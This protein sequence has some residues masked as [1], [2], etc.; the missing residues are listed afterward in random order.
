MSTRRSVGAVAAVVGCLVAVS[1]YA[2]DFQ[3]PAPAPA[4]ANLAFIDGAVDVVQDGVAAPADPPVMLIEGDLVRT[5]N[6]RAE[7][8]FGDG[9]LL[10]L[11]HDTEIEILGE[12]RL[13]LR[14]GRALV[15]V[16]HAAI[17]PYVIDTPSSSVTL[18]AEGEYDVTAT[19]A[20]RFV[21]AVARGA[22]SI[23]YGQRWSIRGGQMLS[24]L[25]PGGRP[26]IE[27]F[28]SARWDAFATW[29]Y[30]RASGFTTSASSAQLPY[31]L[32]P[33]GP[34]LDRYGR[35]DYLEPHGYVWFPS[36]GAAWRP[37]G[38]GAWSFGRY[39]WTWH[40]RDR[41]AWPTH[42]YGRWG[43]TGSF[44]Y[45]APSTVWAPAWVTWSVAPGYVGWAPAGWHGLGRV[46]RWGRPDHPAYAPHDG[47]WRGWTVVPR[48]QFEPRRKVRPSAVDADRLDEATR[49]A[50]LTGAVPTGHDTDH[51]V[52][53]NSLT[54]PGTRGN[55]RRPIAPPAPPTPRA[56]LTGTTSARD[57]REDPS[58]T[59]PSTWSDA[60][61]RSA[62]RGDSGGAPKSTQGSDSGS[63]AASGARSR[64]GSD[65]TGERRGA[66]RSP[67]A[68]TSPRSAPT[69]QSP[70]TR[71]QSR[72]DAAGAA[73][74]S[75]TARPKG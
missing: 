55:V 56:P 18:D 16:S 34:V 49:R 13:R 51:A 6:G 12:E 67:A 73:A 63:G 14:G 21:A 27:P 70:A 53:R 44:W 45:W 42:H 36:V 38:E 60:A 29:S 50:L 25:G 54:R 7:I 57:G 11:S 39:G 43:F 59:R 40:G 28:N 47:P 61:R 46:D 69:A 35:W 65:A 30:D 33:Y 71:G 75:G 41:W 68:R 10:H 74:R 3:S 19:P 5:R 37:Y 64:S 31:E 1:A 24:I 66:V 17:R 2:Q 58:S 8:V 26:L 72:S 22:A 15:R 9:S 62:S 23:D 20:G 48:H 52:P 4:P 32:R